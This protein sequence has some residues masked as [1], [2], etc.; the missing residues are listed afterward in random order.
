[1]CNFYGMDGIQYVLNKWLVSHIVMY[2]F[3]YAYVST[4][5]LIYSF[6]VYAKCQTSILFL[7]FV[8]VH[9]INI[10]LQYVVK[11]PVNIPK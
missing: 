7:V 3:G 1:M 11:E 5:I 10:M 9:N 6:S 2:K 4:G 8:S